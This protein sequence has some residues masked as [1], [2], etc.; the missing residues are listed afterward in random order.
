MCFDPQAPDSLRLC[1]QRTSP[2]QYIGTYTYSSLYLPENFTKAQLFRL[3]EKGRQFLQ[4]ARMKNRKCRSFGQLVTPGQGLL[5]LLHSLTV[6]YYEKRNEYPEYMN[7][8]KYRSMSSRAEGNIA[9]L[10]RNLI[11]QVG[12]ACLS[13]SAMVLG[14]VAPA[15]S[16]KSS[17]TLSN[18]L[19]AKHSICFRRDLLKCIIC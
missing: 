3:R 4:H 12:R 19:R 7:E 10:F 8:R 5:I 1:V 18:S 16:C 13:P 15:P 9:S 11:A 2:S 17:W 14:H 6:K